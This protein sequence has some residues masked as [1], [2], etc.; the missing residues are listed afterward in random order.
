MNISKRRIIMNNFFK[1]Q[2]SYCS[3][4]W[5]CHSRANHFKIN[6]LHERYL[7]IIYSDKTSSFEAL[8][9]TLCWKG[10][11]L[12]TTETFSFLLLKCVRQ[13]KAYLR[14]L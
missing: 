3:L 12:F 4:V 8:L 13:A 6:R 11:S 1:L 14:H 5:V 7:R 10:T 2:F 9:E